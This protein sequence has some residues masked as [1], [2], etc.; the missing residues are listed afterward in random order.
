MQLF[1]LFA[2]LLLPLTTLGGPIISPDDTG[3]EWVVVPSG[4][5]TD[6]AVEARAAPIIVIASK[7]PFP[8][9]SSPCQHQTL[10]NHDK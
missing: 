4:N 10:T 7:S 3:V 5:N 1:A 6:N 8:Y 2:L 9:T